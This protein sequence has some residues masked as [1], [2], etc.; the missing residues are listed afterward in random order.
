MSLICNEWWAC[1][2]T[3]KSDQ[4]GSRTFELCGGECR[5]TCIKW[6]LEYE[7]VILYQRFNIKE[8]ALQCLIVSK[9]TWKQS[10]TLVVSNSSPTLLLE[11]L[12]F[13]SFSGG[14]EI[15]WRWGRFA[16]VSFR[17]FKYFHTSF[18]FVL[19]TRRCNESLKLMIP[20]LAAKS[21]ILSSITP[22]KVRRIQLRR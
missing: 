8:A 16:L 17:I 1:V 22:M 10:L 15:C 7:W 4:T 11:F 2:S 6:K 14:I 3:I 21:S 9:L 20:P 19:H 18:A 12:D 5:K 13:H